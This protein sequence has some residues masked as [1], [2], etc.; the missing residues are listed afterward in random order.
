MVV[1]FWVR[2][3]YIQFIYLHKSNED[4]FLVSRGKIPK[5]AN[6]INSQTETGEFLVARKESFINVDIVMQ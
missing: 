1:H 5:K 4:Y 2:I 6:F 3:N